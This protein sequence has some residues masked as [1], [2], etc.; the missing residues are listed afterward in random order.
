MNTT[1]LE[2]KIN[3]INIVKNLASSLGTG[4]FEYVEQVATLIKEQLLQY[5]YSKAVRKAAAQTVVILLNAC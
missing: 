5:P 4:F 3:A 2:N 1:A